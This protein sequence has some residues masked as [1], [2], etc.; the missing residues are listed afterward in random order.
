MFIRL[1]CLVLVLILSGCAAPLPKMATPAGSKIGLLVEGDNPPTPLHTHLGMTVFGHF[2][3]QY[4]YQWDLQ[5]KVY[6]TIENRIQQSGFNVVDLRTLGVQHSEITGM[7]VNANGNW[8]VPVNKQ[9]MV[10]KLREEMGLAGVIV[11]KQKRVYTDISCFSY[12]CIESYATNSG[13]F[14]MNWVLTIAYKGVLA[15]E[16]EV[17]NLEPPAAIGHHLDYLLRV[18]VM[19][20]PNFKDPVNPENITEEEFRP[21]RDALLKFVDKVTSEAIALM[22]HP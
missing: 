12:G 2:T 6:R 18:P 13:L 11:L 7:V 14:S 20:I 16:W 17:Y 21:V 5:P 1:S 22:N 9:V 15:Y 19:A 10:K 3:K 4:D 8:T